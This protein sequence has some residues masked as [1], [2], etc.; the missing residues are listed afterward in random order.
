MTPDFTP[1]IGVLHAGAAVFSVGCTGHGVAMTQMN[2]RIICDLILGRK[3][4]LT[5]LWFVNHRS[6]PMPPEPVRSMVAGA[7]KAMMIV[8]DWWCERSGRR[9]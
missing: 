7:V 2:G 4:E 9:A 5:E 8:D 6:I 1:Q 3:S